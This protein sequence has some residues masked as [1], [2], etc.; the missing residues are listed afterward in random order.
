VSQSS[1]AIEE[2]LANIQNVTATLVK[3]AENVNGLTAASEAGRAGLQT[4]STDIQE[5]ARESEGLLQINGVILAIAAK[6]NLLAMTAALEAAHAGEAG[7]GFAVV[8]GESRVLAENAGSQS[9]TI[10][11]VLKKIKASIEKITKS[12]NTVLDQFQAIDDSVR[13]VSAQET[14][15]R[16]AMEEQ[17]RGSKQILEAIARLNDVTQEVK[18]GSSEMRE[19]SLQVI[20]ESKNLE[21]VTLE[22]TRGMNEMSAGADEINAAVDRVNGI[23][24]QNREHINTLVEAV[25]KYKVE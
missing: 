15:I 11:G 4:V 6:T 18:R 10:G 7:R 1:S 21:T 22:I 12:A 5:I 17:D 16:A 23:S 24:G 2:M 8:A 19:G 13:T 3:N 14:N 25:A 20:N 9:K